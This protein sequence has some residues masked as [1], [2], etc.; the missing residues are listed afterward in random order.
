MIQEQS[1]VSLI[2]E[3]RWI[4]GRYRCRVQFEDG[5]SKLCWWSYATSEEAEREGRDQAERAGY[6]VR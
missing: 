2:V 6:V 3:Q 5:S 1:P 4:D